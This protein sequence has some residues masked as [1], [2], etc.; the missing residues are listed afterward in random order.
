[1]TGKFLWI[2]ATFQIQ[3]ALFGIKTETKNNGS[4]WNNQADER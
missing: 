1:M 4:E 3:I 2:S